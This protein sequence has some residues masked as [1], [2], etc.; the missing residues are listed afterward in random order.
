MVFWTRLLQK[1]VPLEKRVVGE[2]VIVTEAS[3]F[4]TVSEAGNLSKKVGVRDDTV[5]AILS[6][7]MLKK[8]S[9]QNLN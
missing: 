1:E 9:R 8:G 5:F 3:C 7:K 2:Y 6:H 4:F